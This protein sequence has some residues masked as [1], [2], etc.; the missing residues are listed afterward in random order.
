M[1]EIYN[2]FKLNL[3]LNAKY[4]KIFNVNEAYIIRY[5]L[6]NVKLLTKSIMTS[7]FYDIKVL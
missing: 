6:I 2:K 1:L 4:L 3:V 5:T 7:K